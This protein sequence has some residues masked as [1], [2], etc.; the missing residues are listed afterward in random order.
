MC[1]RRCSSNTQTPKQ[2]GSCPLAIFL[3]VWL[4]SKVGQ[5]HTC[6]VYI[7]YCWKGHHQIYGHVRDI[8]TVLASPTHIQ[9]VQQGTQEISWWDAAHTH[10]HTHTHTGGMQHTHTHTGGMQHT[11]STGGIQHTH[12]AVAGLSTKPCKGS[13]ALVF[14]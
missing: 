2:S 7:Q 11:H 14:E 8:Y 5:N 3:F 12:K 4:V 13:I 10:T 1:D 9:E 6:T